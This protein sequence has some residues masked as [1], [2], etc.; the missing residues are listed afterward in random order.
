MTNCVAGNKAKNKNLTSCLPDYKERK[1]GVIY[2]V[3]QYSEFYKNVK[4]LSAGC[5]PER[6]AHLG[7]KLQHG[8]VHWGPGH[9]HDT[10]GNYFH[11]ISLQ[12]FQGTV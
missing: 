2:S 10:Q 3:K 1:T 5:L 7:G 11:L 6:E 8:A 4:M 12:T 9:C